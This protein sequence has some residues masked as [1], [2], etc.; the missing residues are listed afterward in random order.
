VLGHQAGEL[1]VPLV[2]AVTAST[3]GVE[4]SL[5]RYPECFSH[6]L[7]A[8]GVDAMS[9]A[10]RRPGRLKDFEAEVAVSE[11]AAATSLTEA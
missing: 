5:A 11:W 4:A 8:S 6:S 7:A 10:H 9:C 2:A 3:P 1:R